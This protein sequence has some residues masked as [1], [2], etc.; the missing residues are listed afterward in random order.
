V[1]FFKKIINTYK[2]GRLF[3]V[4]YAR[5]RL[6][7][8]YVRFIFPVFPRSANQVIK[9][10]C[11][12]Y[13][14]PDQSEI[15]L[16][17]RIFNAY[18]KMK[19]DEENVPGFYL[20]SPMWKKQFDKSYSYFIKAR[21]K[22]NIEDFHFFLSNFGT[23]KEYTGVESSTIIRNHMKSFIKR[24]YLKNDLF[25]NNLKVWKWFTNESRQIRQLSYPTYGNQ[26][27]A[28][29]DGEFVGL[30]S[31]FNEIYG[32]HLAELISDIER[33]TIADLGAGYGKLAYFIL[34]NIKEFTFIDFDLPETLCLAAY[35]LMKVFPHKKVLLYGEEEY[36]SNLHQKYDLIFMP[37]Y[38]INK[39]GELSVDLFL[40]KNSLGEMTKEAVHNFTKYI[41]LAT[42][43]YFFH[44][45]HEKHPN[46]YN[47]N[48]CGLLAHEYPISKDKFKLLWRYPDMGHI[49]KAG[50]LD[51]NM[52]IFFYLYEQKKTSI[53]K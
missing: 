18:K 36:S 29:I 11:P 49:L 6:Y 31:Y 16:V 20:P 48:E 26:A 33:P 35:Y 2:E 15:E 10:H 41:S 42:K 28:Y 24:R 52:D 23:W 40:N 14:N 17:K 51:Y 32:T 53:S 50:F 8:R 7:L 43:K 45:N 30:G 47:N 27:G 37:A 1:L 34:R 25:Y 46:I 4:I 3:F 9:I 19:K 21:N 22:N 38:E 44:M 5:C 39:I 12:N 13:I